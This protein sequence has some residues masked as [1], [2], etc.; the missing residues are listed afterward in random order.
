VDPVSNKID[1]H[2]IMVLMLACSFS[3]FVPALPV[4]AAAAEHEKSV[5]IVEEQIDRKSY[6]VAKMLVKAK[7]DQVWQ[8]LTDFGS[9][10]RVFPTLKQCQVLADKGSSKLIHYQVKP[11]GVL[12]SF[13]YDLEVQEH[14]RT[15]MEW[16][17]VDGDFK[18]V[19]GFW[20]LEPA[21]CGH[22]TVVTYASYVNG[23]MFMPQALIKRQSRIDVPPM[24][25]ALKSHAESLQIASHRQQHNAD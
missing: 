3:S 5:A 8:I 17:R 20:K 4:Q 25:V 12:T 19:N 21:D 23:G 1:K 6:I 2:A 13:Q 22:S 10:T 11:T 7:P 14:G 18:E 9:A 15:K 24:M 16:H